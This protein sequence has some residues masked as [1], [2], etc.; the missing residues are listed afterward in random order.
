M[1]VRGPVPFGGLRCHASR[2]EG[3]LIHTLAESGWVQA[4]GQVS[5]HRGKLQKY[6]SIRYL[7][8]VED[9]PEAQKRSTG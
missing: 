8:R 3:N 5:L 1:G 7:Q 4:Q 2:R 6:L 9:P